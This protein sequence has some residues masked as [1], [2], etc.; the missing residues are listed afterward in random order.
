M[1]RRWD[2]DRQTEPGTSI[3]GAPAARCGLRAATAG[4]HPTTTQHAIAAVAVSCYESCYEFGMPTA[5]RLLTLVAMLT[6][7]RPVLAD[8]TLD[9]CHDPSPSDFF[10]PAPWRPDAPSFLGTAC[11][12]E[13]YS[14]IISLWNPEEFTL[15]SGAT[16]PLESSS[17]PQFGGIRG[18]PRG[19]T[20]RCAPA[21]CFFPFPGSGASGHSYCIEIFGT[22]TNE[23]PPETY[24]LSFSFGFD[25]PFTPVIDLD[26]PSYFEPDAHVYLKLEETGCPEPHAT[27]SG[28]AGL[29]A[30][31]ALARRRH[32]RTGA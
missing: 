5:L 27:L 31:G 21:N 8:L 3:D 18:L 25:S 14:Q 1:S 11:V 7:A 23:N 30:L 10:T 6:L 12:G 9:D 32:G 19:L 26:Y 4:D 17:L 20:Y 15:Q 28:V 16:L 22:P 13:P 29:G 2:L 24:D